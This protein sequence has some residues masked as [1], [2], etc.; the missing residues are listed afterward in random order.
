MLCEMELHM[1]SC[2]KRVTPLELLLQTK[3]W[4]LKAL[5]LVLLDP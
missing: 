1:C 5:L 4:I 2:R 3:K